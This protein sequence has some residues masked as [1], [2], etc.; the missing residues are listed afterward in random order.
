M[1]AI[2]V[3][4]LTYLFV[5]LHEGS[6]SYRAMEVDRVFLPL[7]VASVLAVVV[8]FVDQLAGAPPRAGSSAA[9]SH[10]WA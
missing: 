1:L 7:F 8:G 9:C 10:S 3:I 5:Y 4:L 6:P 2:A